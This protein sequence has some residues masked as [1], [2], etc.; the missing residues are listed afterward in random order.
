LVLE[1][2]E[3]SLINNLD[4]VHG[5]LMELI[6]FG[7]RIALDDFGTGYSSL[8]MLQK[9]PVQFVKLD[10]EFIN[11]LGTS[12]DTFSIVKAVIKLCHI[13]S[14]EVIAEGVETEAQYRTLKELGCNYFQGYYFS[15]PMALEA[16]SALI[17]KPDIP[18]GES[19]ETLN[20]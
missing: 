11:G 17:N 12:D 5:Q 20:Q 7:V 8:A 19:L 2:T 6:D 18:L 10:R 1:I 9:L 3:E 16:F 15:K 14:L 13:L 4:R